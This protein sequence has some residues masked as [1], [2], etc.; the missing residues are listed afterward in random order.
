MLRL[1]NDDF[2]IVH[3]DV[4]LSATGHVVYPSHATRRYKQKAPLG[5]G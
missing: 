4:K 2:A 3:M 5:T 1:R